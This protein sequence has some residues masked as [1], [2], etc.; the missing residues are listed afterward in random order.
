MAVFLHTSLDQ[1]NQLSSPDDIDTCGDRMRG[2]YHRFFLKIFN[3]AVFIHS[4]N[5]KSCDIFARFHIFTYNSD[6]RFLFDMIFQ[7]FIIIQFVYTI[8]GSNNYIWLMTFLEK[9]SERLFLPS[10]SGCLLKSGRS[11]A[12]KI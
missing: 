6:I 1:L 7:N 2:R 10:V 5:A 4:D 12:R 8:S 3:S 9:R 11:A